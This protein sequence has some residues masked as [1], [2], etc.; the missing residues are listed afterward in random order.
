MPFT[1]ST[2]ASGL[3]ALEPTNTPSVGYARFV[4]AYAAYV[5]ECTSNG[6]S[7]IA[8]YIDGALSTAMLVPM[9]GLSGSTSISTAATILASAI[10]AFWG[11][12]VTNP[13]LMFATAT[14]LTPPPY[15]DLE[16]DLET[17]LQANLDN[18]RSLV[19]AA[20][21][22]AAAIHGDRLGGTVTFP[23]LSPTPI[24]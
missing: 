20:A 1:E 22:I 6:A 3:E 4:A 23:S 2:L 18:E 10:V 11:P 12:A 21:A 15:L 24:L 8:A 16:A 19:D 5:K 7:P 13:E 14:E 9:A 17:A